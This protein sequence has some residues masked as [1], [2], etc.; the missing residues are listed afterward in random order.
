[1]R[2]VAL[3]LSLLGGW[4][5]YAR[6]GGVDEFLLPAPSQ[7]AESAFVD[8]ALLWSNFTV[9][10]AEML[11]GLAVALAAGIALAVAVHFS[12]TLRRAT[13]PLL[14]ASQT[15]P[16][17]VIAPLLVAWLGFDLAPK[18]AIVGLVCFFPVVV[19]TLDGLASVDPDLGKLMR[20]LDASR[21]QCFRYVDAPAALPA[22]LSGARIAVAVAA[23]GAV[24]AEQAGSSEGLGHLIV[25]AQPQF[26]T[27]RGWA[28]VVLLSA[29]TVALFGLLTMAERRALPWAHRTRGGLA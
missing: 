1:M 16:I 2:A 21:V 25:Q 23:I 28:A 4:E 19:T 14:V 27:A 6:I 5:L 20:T 24:L 3:A 9:T 8:R 7:I 12:R 26:Q 13:Y 11:L 10:A 17:V 15:I 18:L 22:L 29:F